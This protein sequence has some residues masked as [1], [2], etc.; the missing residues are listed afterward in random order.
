MEFRGSAMDPCSF[1][2]L[3]V[4]GLEVDVGLLCFVLLTCLCISLVKYLQSLR[5]YLINEKEKLHIF[6]EE[7]KQENNRQFGF[8]PYIC[9]FSLGV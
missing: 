5:S 1:S 2:R 6:L 7:Y 4:R 3:Y 8:C 9:Q